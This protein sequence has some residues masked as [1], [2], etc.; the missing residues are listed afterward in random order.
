MSTYLQIG[1]RATSVVI[2]LKRWGAP[3]NLLALTWTN[4]V[5]R[6]RRNVAMKW[7]RAEHGKAWCSS[8]REDSAYQALMDRYRPGTRLLLRKFTF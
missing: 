8:T 7:P 2:A 3:Y 6:T 5:T 4:P 1:G